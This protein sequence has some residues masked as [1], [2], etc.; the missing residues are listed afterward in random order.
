MSDLHPELHIA[1]RRVLAIGAGAVAAVLAV[2]LA[3]ATAQQKSTPAASKDAKGAADDIAKAGPRGDIVLGKPDAPVTIVE[4][5]SMTCGHCASFHNT[6][7]PALKQKY[8]ETGK[9]KLVLREFPLD[10]LAAAVSM[11]ARCAPV[12]KAPEVIAKF[13]ET[14]DQWIPT[15]RG[16]PIPGLFKIAEPLGFAKDAFDKCLKDDKLLEDVVAVGERARKSF[17]VN[18][19]PTFFINGKKLEIRGDAM[20]SFDAAI[21]PLLKQ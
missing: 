9:A 13:F 7:L 5:A 1:R 2:A 14:Q 17:G 11:L 6:V 20:A 10:N 19:T 3:P 21:E 15:G 4:Y 8:I 18:S 12:E 16:S